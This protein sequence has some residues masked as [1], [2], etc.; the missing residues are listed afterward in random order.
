M[1]LRR[2][3]ANYY[4]E[5]VLLTGMFIYFIAMLVGRSKNTT[6]A[7]AWFKANKDLLEASFSIVGKN[8]SK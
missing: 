8:K 2:D 4:V 7:Q 6:L 3:W 1:N 5:M